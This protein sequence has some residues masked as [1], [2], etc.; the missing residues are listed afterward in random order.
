MIQKEVSNTQSIEAST[1]TKF[2][3]DWSELGLSFCWARWF[4]AW[5]VGWLAGWLAGAFCFLAFCGG[6][7]ICKTAY[8]QSQPQLNKDGQ[9]A[10]FWGK[11]VAKSSHVAMPCHAIRCS[12]R[13]F[14]VVI[15]TAFGPTP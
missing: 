8:H 12:A 7:R 6:R 10:N 3:F 11:G 13:L 9:T 5:L 2:D 1:T 15:W 14:I 4:V